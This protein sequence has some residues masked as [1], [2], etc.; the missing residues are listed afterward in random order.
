MSRDQLHILSWTVAIVFA[1]ALGFWRPR[2]IHWTLLGA[3]LLFAALNTGAGIYVLNHFADSRWSSGGET[4]LTTPSISG[5]PL[6]GQYLAPLDSALKNVVGGVNDFLAF[7]HALPTALDFLAVAGWALL[8]SFPVAVVATGINY[9]VARRRTAEPAKY[10]A[11]VDQLRD[12]L[13]EVKRQIASRSIVE[14]SSP[15]EKVANEFGLG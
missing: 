13:D 5:T 8:V 10:R 12:E 2:I 14:P 4:P 9:T 7:K 1:L 6:V 15:T 11:A 3:V